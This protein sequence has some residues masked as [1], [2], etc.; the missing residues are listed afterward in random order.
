M[1]ISL[2]ALARMANVPRHRLVNFELGG[3]TLT[4]DEENR[5]ATALRKEAARL[6]SLSETIAFEGAISA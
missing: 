5:I 2:S 4:P 3:G 6:R 1:K